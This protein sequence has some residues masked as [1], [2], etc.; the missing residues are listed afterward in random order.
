MELFQVR[1]SKRKGFR[2]VTLLDIISD[3]MYQRYLTN[4]ITDH[5]TVWR[6]DFKTIVYDNLRSLETTISNQ[7]KYLL[8]PILLNH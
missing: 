4:D 2:N 7:Q 5:S 8:P 6:P 1:K 3:K